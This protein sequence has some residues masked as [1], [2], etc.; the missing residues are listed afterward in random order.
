VT[1][2]GAAEE[3]WDIVSKEEE[4]SGSFA[5]AGEVE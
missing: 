4:L 2:K 3:A 1:F 5:E